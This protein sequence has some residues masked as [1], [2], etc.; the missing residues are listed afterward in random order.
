MTER[1][2]VGREEAGPRGKREISE[3]REEM[4]GPFGGIVANMILRDREGGA[5]ND[6]AN[7]P[8]LYC[9]NS[10]WEDHMSKG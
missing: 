7:S 4:T 8:G 6:G 1:K 10:G 5:G 9:G 2:G 3:P